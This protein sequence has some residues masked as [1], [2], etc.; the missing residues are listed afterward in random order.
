LKSLHKK[1]IEITNNNNIKIS[2]HSKFF[3]LIIIDLN[4]LGRDATA[5]FTSKG[6]SGD[7]PTTP[8]PQP[9]II[10]NHHDIPKIFLCK[11]SE[12]YYL[13]PLL[14]NS[15]GIENDILAKKE[16][17]EKKSVPH[18]SNLGDILKSRQLNMSPEDLI[19]EL[20]QKKYDQK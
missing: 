19:D 20:I 5:H 18:N 7:F 10:L 8:T 2:S 13:I 3:T 12:L 14:E 11:A 6:I 1:I 4:L 9:N 15:T 17:E 16:P